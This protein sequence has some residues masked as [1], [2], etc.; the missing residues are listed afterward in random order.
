MAI[1]SLMG[2]ELGDIVST[3]YFTGPYE[4]TK[5][6]GPLYSDRDISDLVTIFPWPYMNLQCVGKSCRGEQQEALLNGYHQDPRGRLVSTFGDLLTVFKPEHRRPRQ[7]SLFDPPDPIP[8]VYPWQP[9]VDYDSWDLWNCRKCSADF[10]AP[11]ICERHPVYRC[12]GRCPNGCGSWES[13]PLAKMHPEDDWCWAKG[14]IRN[15]AKIRQL[16]LQK[17]ERPGA[18]L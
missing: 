7:A 8:G 9:G 5:I 15:G 1:Q 6:T 16:E 11:K 12:G 10:N 14:L 4:V 2:V 18:S 17:T 13:R 3:S